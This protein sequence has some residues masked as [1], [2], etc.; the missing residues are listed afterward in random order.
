MI[1]LDTAT[2]ISG[3]PWG[4]GDTTVDAGSLRAIT[5]ELRG[6]LARVLYEDPLK[7]TPDADLE[8]I[9][10]DSIL[11][12]EFLSAVNDR[13]GLDERLDVVYEHSS[14]ARLAAYIEAQPGAVFP[15]R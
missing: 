14:L 11:A 3:L 6:F 13:Y 5:E 9:G 8:D 15:P 1:Y 7:I 4:R 10:L 12:V 2:G